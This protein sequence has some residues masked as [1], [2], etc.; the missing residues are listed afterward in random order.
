MIVK[1]VMSGHVK[2][3][4]PEIPISEAARIMRDNG[5]GCVPIG[6]NDRLIGMITD[7]DITCRAVAAGDDLSNVTARDVM[8]QG[9]FFCFEDEAL[10]KAVIRGDFSFGEQILDIADD[11]S[12]DWIETANGRTVMNKEFVLRSKLRIE[13]RQFHMSRL[14]RDTWGEATKLDVKHHYS[15]MTEA[16]RLKKAHELVGLIHQIQKGPELPPPLEYRPE[17]PEEEPQ[18]S[19][20]GGRL[21]RF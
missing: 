8:S 21:H 19:G 11:A 18:P 12:N 20:I 17:E 10:D 7:R 16:E 3:I 9:I 2:W 6:E 15:Q 5:I 1:E 4:A 14:H 13:A